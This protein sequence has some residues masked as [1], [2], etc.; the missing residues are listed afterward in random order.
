MSA[1]RAEMVAPNTAFRILMNTTRF[2]RRPTLALCLLGALASAPLFIAGCG[3]ASVS[4]PTLPAGYTAQADLIYSAVSQPNNA[5]TLPVTSLA[6][7]SGNLIGSLTTSSQGTQNVE[8]SGIN[9][10]I[11]VETTRRFD[12]FLEAPAGQ[13]FAVGQS[14]PLSFGTRNTILIRQSNPNGDRLWQSDG[15]TATVTSVGTNAISLRLTDARFVPSP[16]F[17][18]RGIFILNGTIGA[19]SLRVASSG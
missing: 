5:L 4:S 12:V 17:F 6:T 13:G 9:R 2:F 18:G 3:G 19:R 16:T 14:Y 8:F 10:L 7:D 11:N 1:T 15:G